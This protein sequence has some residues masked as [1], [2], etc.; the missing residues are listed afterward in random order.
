MEWNGSTGTFAGGNG[1]GVPLY[2]HSSL[3]S[4]HLFESF[5]DISYIDRTFAWDSILVCFPDE[6]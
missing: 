1:H 3:L 4:L 2:F 5:I 6:L